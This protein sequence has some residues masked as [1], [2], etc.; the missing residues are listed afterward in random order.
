MTVDGTQMLNVG[1][2][3]T[4]YVGLVT[5]ACLSELGH[6]VVCVDNDVTKVARLREGDIPI[7][8]LGSTSLSG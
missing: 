2:V 5:G 3:E 1:I 6:N 8:E 4:G 7:Q